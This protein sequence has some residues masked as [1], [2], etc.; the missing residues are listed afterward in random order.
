MALRLESFAQGICTHC[1]HRVMSALP[2]NL[3]GPA[4]VKGLDKERQHKS[5][6]DLWPYPHLFPPP[7]SIPVHGSLTG[8]QA[9]AVPAGG[10]SVVICSYQVP[11]GFR[12]IMQA[13]LESFAGIFIP[14]DSLFT[15]MVNPGGGPQATYVQGLI[16]T[17]VPLGSWQYGI[18][19]PFERPYEFASLDLITMNGLNVNLTQGPPNQYVGG[20]FGYLIEG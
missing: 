12:F 17:P 3:R 10:S 9:V 5:N 2:Q 11:E 13:I 20:F 15:V 19:W 18:Q 8:L 4:L 6:Q 1:F 7:A 14:G 16:N